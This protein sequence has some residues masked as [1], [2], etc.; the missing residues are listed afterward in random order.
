MS[1]LAD[2]TGAIRA[3]GNAALADSIAATAADAERLF[4]RDF[5]Y[6]SSQLG[7]LDGLPAPGARGLVGHHRPALAPAALIS[8]EKRFSPLSP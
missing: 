4:L 3:R 7:L 6:M 1:C 2:Y 8:R 5:D